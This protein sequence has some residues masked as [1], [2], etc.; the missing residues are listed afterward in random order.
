MELLDYR[1]FQIGSYEFQIHQLV[2]II[3]ITIFGITVF[4]WLKVYLNPKIRDWETVTDAQRKKLMRII[5]MFFIFLGTLA[6]VFV[7]GLNFNI[8]PTTGTPIY[9][10]F[11]LE[12]LAIIQ[13][14]RLLDWIVSS[15]FIHRNFVRRDDEKEAPKERDT[16]GIATR[17]VQFLVYIIALILIIRTLD[18]DYV[19]TT[20]QLKDGNPFDLKLSNVFGA[21]AIFLVG[22]LLIWIITQLFLYGYYKRKGID[23][24]A[25]FAV[26]QLISY[27]GYFI[28]ILLALETMGINMTLIWGGA[29]A[30]LVGV[31]LGLQQTFNDF[32]SG[33][34]L[35]FE[36]TVKVGDIVHM[37][38]LTGMV[39]KIGLRASIVESR[40]AVSVIVPNSKLVNES[41]VNW[42]HLSDNIRFH[43]SVG[44]A[45]GS[46][47][48]L[49]KKL[50]LQAAKENKQVLKFPAP[51]VRFMEFADSS[52]NFD[53]YYFSK[54]LLTEQ[55]VK[56]N[57]RFRVDELF[58][59][60][61]IK[62]PF[63]QSEIYVHRQG[64]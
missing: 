19:L 8:S 41:I 4:R 51:F 52:L 38:G 46:D 44:V 47:T 14:A 53:L 31:G 3:L 7:L 35:L 12:A 60:N 57:L 25:Q 33:I 20:V 22:R 30:L 37:D 56:S 55:D 17:T 5:S 15:Y 54:Q 49:V 11:I 59:S 58:R 64:E 24:G 13:F 40:D 61:K 18:L 10:S 26:N 1:L 34:V 23:I 32:F 28:A 62:I 48:E 29:A 21:I 63:P 45:Y 27:V 2:S 39:K 16:E 6:V 43:I 36:R 9:I 50:L 42:S